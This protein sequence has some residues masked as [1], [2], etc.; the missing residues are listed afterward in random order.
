MKVNIFPSRRVCWFAAIVAV[1]A[2]YSQVNNAS[3]SGLVNDAS[4]GVIS[5][6]SVTVKNNSTNVKREVKT[7]GAGYY[8]F[9]TLPVGD[10][11][12][13]VAHPGFQTAVE[14][15]TLQTAQKARLDFSLTVGQ[16]GTTV[17]VES[18]APQLSPDDATLGTVIDNSYVSKFPLTLRSWDDLL[19]LVAGVQ[20]SRYTEQSGATSAGRTGGFNV[21]GVRSLQNNFI[22][23]GVDNNTFSEN[24]QELST[25][26]VR[27]SV[28][29]IQEFKVI[30]NPYSAEY[31]RSPGAAVVV[32][33]KSGTNQIHGLAYEYLRNS[34]LDAN[35]FFSNRSGLQK[36]E[37]QR[38]QFGANFG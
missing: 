30:T 21:H 15:V 34:A 14:R 3:L 31:G 5:G 28:D 11:E 25:Q 38:N 7:D 37:N 17:E 13:S 12:V 1:G 22:L 4:Q 36:P 20:G 35:D 23:D 9:A 8:S 6:V 2:A 27:P 29:D 19:N 18:A 16:V 33:T 10:Y 32:T 24:V 26:A